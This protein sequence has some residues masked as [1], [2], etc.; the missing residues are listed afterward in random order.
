MHKALILIHTALAA[1]F[2]PM[3]LMY[4]V[5]GGFYGLGITG[6]YS[7]E[8]YRLEL[9]RSLPSELSGLVALAEDELRSRDLAFPTGNARIRRGGTSYYFEWTGTRRD[10]ELHPTA[11]PNTAV[12]KVKD[13]SPHRFFVQLHKAKG[14]EWFKLFAA[15]WMVGLVCLFLT[16]GVMAFVARRHRPVAIVAGTL[17]LAS[18]LLLAW[19]S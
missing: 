9:D 12:F 15:T 11:E 5:T 2:L 1:F 10:V 19:I 14:G 8:E 7:I 6:N 4:A 16:G 3:G 17:G 18:F 13:T